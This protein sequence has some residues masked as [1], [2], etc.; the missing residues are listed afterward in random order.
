MRKALS[1]LALVAVLAGCG[2]GQPASKGATPA[3]RPR[4]TIHACPTAFEMRSVRKRTTAR[5]NPLPVPRP[6]RTVVRHTASR[7]VTR[8]PLPSPSP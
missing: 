7:C 6:T 4:A 8:T 2:A 5:Y 1:A 3:P